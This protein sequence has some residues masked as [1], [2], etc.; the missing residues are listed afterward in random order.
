MAKR[1]DTRPL[2]EHI[3][4]REQDDRASLRAAWKRIQYD[5]GNRSVT[6]LHVREFCFYVFAKD[7]DGR[8]VQIKLEDIAK[9]LE[10]S[11]STA[12]KIVRRA[13]MEFG[14]VAVTEERYATGSQSANRY[15][16][17]WP[18]VRSINAGLIEPVTRAAVPR[19]HPPVPTEQPHALSGQGAVPTEQHIKE[20]PRTIPRHLPTHS[21]QPPATDRAADGGDPW[22]VVVSAFE[23][24]EMIDARG[25]VGLAQQ[26][27]LTPADVQSLIA[28]YVQLTA[29]DSGVT[30][31]Y[32]HRWISGKSRPPSANRPAAAR[33]RNV[34]LT[35]DTTRREMIRARI[36][37]DGRRAGDSEDA[38]AARVRA[39]WAKMAEDTQG[40]DAAM[41]ARRSELLRG[42]AV[43]SHL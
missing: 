16:I 12:R 33:P 23:E 8:G 7:G 30:I 24:L 26:R 2:I 29:A 17:D 21:Q 20:S 39:A 42:F 14:L 31:G 5:R 3:E 10:C 38:I 18:V 36:V 43:G 25:A 41:Q 13:S 35:S 34:S 19:R 6:D 9:E 28:E 37:R 4:G 15:S 1:T 11:Y 27:G 40:S 32:L 22:G